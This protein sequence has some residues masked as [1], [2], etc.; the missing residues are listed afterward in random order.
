MND[1][2][3]FISD[4]IYKNPYMPDEYNGKI[5][6]YTSPNGF[7]SILFDD[8]KEKVTLWASRYD[9]LNDMSEGTIASHIYK[10]VCKK[11]LESKKI[12]KEQYDEITDLRA[13]K[14]N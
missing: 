6:H 13:D 11:L 4:L 8:K 1:F 12:T 10:E 9:C 2:N 5:F 3:K 14:K 7:N